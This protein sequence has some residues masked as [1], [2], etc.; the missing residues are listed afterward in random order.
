MTIH[1]ATPRHSLL[2]KIVIDYSNSR[3]PTLGVIYSLL[4]A[5]VSGLLRESSAADEARTFFVLRALV[6]LG[7]LAPAIYMVYRRVAWWKRW[8]VYLIGGACLALI[9]LSAYD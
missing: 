9:A 5:S 3:I 2:R 4:T 7:M 8:T 1:R 6:S